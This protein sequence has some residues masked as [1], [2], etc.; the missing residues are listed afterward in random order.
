MTDPDA[1]AATAEGGSRALSPRQRLVSRHVGCVF[2]LIAGSAFAL[3]FGLFVSDARSDPRQAYIPGG[4]KRPS[5]AVQPPSTKS[6]EPV[7]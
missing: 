7:M 5:W 4:T 3:A 1:T 2:T 6:T